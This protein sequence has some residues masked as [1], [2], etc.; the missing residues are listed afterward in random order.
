MR[1]LPP[2][3]YTNTNPPATTGLVPELPFR[4][5]DVSWPPD[6]FQACVP[7]P[8]AANTHVPS[9]ARQTAGAVKSALPDG[10]DSSCTSPP[11]FATVP[12]MSDHFNTRMCPSLPPCATSPPPSS[13]GDV[14]PRSASVLL[15]V[16]VLAGV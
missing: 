2:G 9:L 10:V 15:S 1:R 3:S 8:S 16:C 5:T 14:E 7:P 4:Q 13:T 11:E 6:S 12:R